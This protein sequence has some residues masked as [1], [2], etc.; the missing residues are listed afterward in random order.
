MVVKR[1]NKG[2]VTCASP[3]GSY[4]DLKVIWIMEDKLMKRK[5]QIHIS[6]CK[7]NPACL[8]YLFF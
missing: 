7:A 5:A 3:R 1:D 6:P 4:I 8:T 2:W